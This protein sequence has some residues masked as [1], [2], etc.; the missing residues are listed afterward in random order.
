MLLTCTACGQDG[1]VFSDANTGPFLVSP[2]HI[3]Q[4]RAALDE[5]PVLQREYREL[6]R[7]ADSLYTIAFSPVTDK[8]SLPPG[9]DPHDYY[10]LC[11]YC[12]SDRD[13][14]VRYDESEVNPEV[15]DSARYD[16]SRLT[17][18]SV[19]SY[20]LALAYLYSGEERYAE[21]VSEILRKWF[22]DNETRMNPNFR[23]AQVVPGREEGGLQGII[24]AREFIR[25]IE[26]ANLVYDS[27]S[28]T[29][30]NHYDLKQWFY[31]FYGWIR[32][33]Y[34]PDAYAG[35]NVST[36]LDAQRT[37]Y[38]LFIEEENRLN[39]PGHIQLISERIDAQ[40][41]E[42]GIQLY[43]SSRA[44]GQH[45]VFFN[46]RGY[47]KL[48]LMRQRRGDQDR[49]WPLLETESYGGM[50]PA[51][52]DIAGQVLSA[53]TFRLFSETE[54]FDRCRYLEVLVPFAAA[55]GNEEYG[56]AARQLITEGCSN[57][58]TTLSYAVPELL[59]RPVRDE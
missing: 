50:R 20:V 59:K 34:Q 12:Y 8:Q 49:D 45:Y 54:G 16:R 3:E 39:H 23:Y 5:S 35:S 33:R 6:I 14:G 46:L 17:N 1:P 22:L 10:S 43:E 18:L 9:G 31:D 13:G 52:D 53:G 57:S 36:W 24:E 19:S 55:F 7:G 25:V 32:S 28:W 26:A 27:P 41:D 42:G 44:Q 21:R 51:I 4:I 40:F 11:T 30:E 29:P 47:S 38:L 15:Y 58:I 56:R 37:I 48:A 2:D